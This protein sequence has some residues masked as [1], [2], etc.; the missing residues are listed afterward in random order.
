MPRLLTPSSKGSYVEKVN[1]DNEK[2]DLMNA[3]EQLEKELKNMKTR[4]LMEKKVKE[5]I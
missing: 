5:K 1:F 2:H 3:K 4:E